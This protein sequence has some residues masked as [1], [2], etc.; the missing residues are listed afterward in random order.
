[1][2]RELTERDA[3]TLIA[4]HIEPHPAHPGITEYRLK[5][6]DNGYPVW[7][8]VGSLA[9]DGSNVETVARDF[10]ISTEAIAAVW[11]FYGRHKRAIDARLASIR[12]A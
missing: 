9:P 11:A 5:V 10:E 3:D 12:A 6:A 2:V 4:A 1:M 8:V 7:S